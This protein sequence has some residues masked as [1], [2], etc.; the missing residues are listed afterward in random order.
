MQARL[1]LCDP[2]DCSPPGAFN[3]EFLQARTLEWV[4]I[5]FFTG[6]SQPRSNTRL[7]YH[8]QILYHLSC[9]AGLPISE[10]KTATPAPMNG[11][12]TSLRCEP[13][14]QR[15]QRDGL[16]TT[17]LL[18]WVSALLGSGSLITVREGSEAD[19]KPDQKACRDG[20]AISTVV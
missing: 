3:H 2:I 1:I 8:R 4:T 10:M 16:G 14:V 7:L 19:A 20:L 9:K 12:E 11:A 15:A 6:S 5:P 17:K 18:S 13:A